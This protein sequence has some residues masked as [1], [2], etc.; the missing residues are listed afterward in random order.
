MRIPYLL[1]VAA[2]SFSAGCAH[3]IARCGEDLTGLSTKQEVHAQLGEPAAQGVV[4]GEP[5]EEFL[6]RRKIAEPH[7]LSALGQGMPWG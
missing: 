6:T 4:D 2:A 1:L 3:M 5:F 7:A